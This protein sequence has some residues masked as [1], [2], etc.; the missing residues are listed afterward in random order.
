[1]RI[2]FDAKRMFLNNRGLGNYA[3]NLMYGL[4][5]YHPENE[6]FLYTTRV[7]NEFISPSLLNS[8]NV[9]VRT[10]EGFAKN[11]SAFWRSYKLGSVSAKDELKIYHGLSHEIPNDFKKSKAKNVVTIHDLI[12]LKHKEF[13]KPID[14]WIYTNKAKFAIKYADKVVAISK[15]TKA[16]LLEEFSIS[17]DRISIVYQSCNEVFY[18]K[19]SEADK[20][21]V[22]EKWNLPENYILYVGAL[23]E[24][25]NVKII[26]EAMAVAGE[27]VDLPLVIV[28]KGIEYKEVVQSTAKSLGLTNRVIFASDRANPS[29]HELSSFY[30][31]ASVFVFPSFYEGFG[32]PIL[33]ARFSEIPV[34]ASNSSCLDEAG[35][36][37]TLYFSPTNAE[38]LADQL[39]IALSSPET[40]TATYPSD[41]KLKPLTKKMMDLY[42]A[43]L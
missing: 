9:H 16:D 24:N 11:T 14:R 28:G 33:E 13:Y 19:R 18:S 42:N 29:P 20:N 17:E 22:K 7:H 4:E 43:V 25:K 3:R 8:K 12:F 35:G 41:F 23:N 39:E 31:M 36:E 34:L 2:G 26:L 32:I 40:L 6:Y 30:Q 37:H 1:M 21:K 5:F 38:E 27:D 15:Q 10:P